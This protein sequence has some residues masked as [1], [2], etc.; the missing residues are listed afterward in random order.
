VVA[1]LALLPATGCGG[2]KGGKEAAGDNYP[3]RAINF[4]VPFSPGG[5]SDLISRAI[6]KAAE[7]P[8]GKS[9]ALTNK[10]G[11]NGAVGGKEVLASAPDGY[12]IALS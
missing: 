3:T 6:A 8:L 9:V 11:A 10:A 4:T 5:S 2:V 12:N 7:K 1:T